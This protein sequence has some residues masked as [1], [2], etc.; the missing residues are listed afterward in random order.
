MVT[1]IRQA[2]LGVLQNRKS[3]LHRALLDECSLHCID[4]LRFSID[5]RA[6]HTKSATVHLSLESRT[7]PAPG[8]L[9]SNAMIMMIP[10]NRQVECSMAQF[11]TAS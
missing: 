5:V 8:S 6:S 4:I 10:V 3:F 1:E 11:V 9:G 7:I 2:Y